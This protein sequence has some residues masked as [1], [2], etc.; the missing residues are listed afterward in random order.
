MSDINKRF[1]TPPDPNPRGK[2]SKKNKS[3]SIDEKKAF[4]FDF[5]LT[6]AD[7]RESAK[8]SFKHA[9]EKCG[10]KYIEE[11]LFAYLTTTLETTFSKI[12]S[13][14]CEFEE[15]C[16]V[17]Y[18]KNLEVICDYTYIYPD[19][20]KLL[21]RL[22]QTGKKLAIVTNRDLESINSFL[23]SKGL[24]NIF[25]AV[26]GRE[27][28]EKQKPDPEPINTC[29]DRLGVDKNEAIYFGPESNPQLQFL[30]L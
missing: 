9:I 11:D 19:A 5:D 10:G 1:F 14:N 16:N 25:D 15:F 23:E 21:Y 8:I 20:D 24:T 28:V 7:T 17:Y 12:E 18:K 22:K 29:L 4:I 13:P 6:I 27:D 3:V 2:A 26:V 30:K